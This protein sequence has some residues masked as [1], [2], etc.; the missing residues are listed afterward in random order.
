[1]S[2]ENIE[3]ARRYFEA[4]NAGGL[5]GTENWRHP[6]VEVFDPPG[7]PDSDRHVGEAAVRARVEEII[8]M[9]WDGQFRNPE[10]LDADPEVAALWELRVS[11]SHGGGFPMDLTSVHLLL[12]ENRK[13]RRIRMF[14]GRDEGLEAAG[15]S[16]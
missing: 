6:D 4:F 15:L 16:E 13:I 10:F 5:E 7:F 12:F 14:V 3:L 11:T 1:M 9:G 2:E 8:D